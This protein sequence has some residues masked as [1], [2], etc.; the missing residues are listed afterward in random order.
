MQITFE[1][2]PTVDSDL[3]RI[4][5]RLLAKFGP[6]GLRGLRAYLWQIDTD[7]E[8]SSNMYKIWCASVL[9][10]SCGLLLQLT[11]LSEYH[12]QHLVSSDGGRHPLDAVGLV[13]SQK[14]SACCFCIWKCG[15]AMLFCCHPWIFVY[16]S[17]CQL[18][19]YDVLVSLSQ[20]V[21]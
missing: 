5:L 9:S 1:K 20:Y 7:T 16:G 14:V 13:Y 3:S 2:F 10:L 17:A 18:I 8:K 15:R 19:W 11:A 4:Y 12:I 21:G 6:A